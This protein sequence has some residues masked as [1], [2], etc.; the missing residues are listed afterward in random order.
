MPLTLP[1]NDG[2]IHDQNG[3]NSPVIQGSEER[4]IKHGFLRNLM[5]NEPASTVRPPRT[6]QVGLGDR[7]VR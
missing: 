4:Q 3:Q 6:T 5:N 1:R 7:L 2:P